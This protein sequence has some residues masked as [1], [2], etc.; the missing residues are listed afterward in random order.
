MYMTKSLFHLHFSLERETETWIP[1]TTVCH[2]YILMVTYN[3]K[4]NSAS[5]RNQYYSSELVMYQHYTENKMAD[6]DEVLIKT[7]FTNKTSAIYLNGT[8][9]I[10]ASHVAGQRDCADIFQSS[11][12]L[13]Q[14]KQ[15]LAKKFQ[16]T[17]ILAT[18]A[19][20]Q[21]IWTWDMRI[22]KKMEKKKNHQ[23]CRYESSLWICR[24]TQRTAI[25]KILSRN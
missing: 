13:P 5:L 22:N 17:L 21:P 10:A 3:L 16:F 12:L 2:G 4:K 8:N 1:G 6:E 24:S 15:S 7:S 18:W 20:N 23:N 11:H 14:Q 25:I 19:Q 9:P